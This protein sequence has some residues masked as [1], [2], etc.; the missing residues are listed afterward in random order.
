MPSGCILSTVQDGVKELPKR[1][2]SLTLGFPLLLFI[3][4][5]CFLSNAVAA[6]PLEVVIEGIEGDAL[7]NAWAALILPPGMVREGAVDRALLDLFL[8][9][10]PEKVRKSLEPFGYY[11]AQVSSNL[12]K[13]EEGHDLLRVKVIP[14]EP[15]RVTAVQVRITGPGR[16]TA[17]S[18]CW[19]TP[20]P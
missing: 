5:A 13:T 19:W 2:R 16:K 6:E 1:I 12:E 9:Q 10:I 11:E 18:G 4:G 3:L 8:R 7:K 15:V 14:G 17:T 20:F